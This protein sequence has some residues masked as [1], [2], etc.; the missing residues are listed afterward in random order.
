MRSVNPKSEQSG[1]TLHYSCPTEWAHRYRTALL[2]LDLDQISVWVGHENE[3]VINR[4]QDGLD[5]L[6]LL[7]VQLCHRPQSEAICASN[8]AIQRQRLAESFQNR[9]IWEAVKSGLNGLNV[10][11]NHS[12]VTK[13]VRAVD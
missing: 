12:D 5:E 2:H 11:Y 7:R 10:W 13:G 9:D 6:P 8:R 1:C 3:R 4:R